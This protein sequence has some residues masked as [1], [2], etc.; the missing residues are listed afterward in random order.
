[1]Q[2][3]R[4]GW[5]S[6]MNKHMEQDGW[7]L[8]SAIIMILFLTAVGFSIAELVALQ[9]QHTKREMYM[10]NAQLVAEAGI[11]QSVHE[12]NTDDSFAGYPTAQTFFDDST[13]GK[14]TFSTAVT[15]NSDGTSKTII[16]T[17][18]VY[19]TDTDPNP[20]LTRKVKVTV[21]G[22]GSSGYSVATGPGGLILGGSASITN[23][24]VYVDGTITMTGSSKIGT[25]S[26][27]VNV[28][29]GN[30]ACPKGSSPGSSYP[31]V[32][33]D[34]SQPIS[35]DWSTNIYGT[36]CATGQ[37][38][39]GPNNNIQG[40]NGGAGLEVGCTAPSVTPPTYDRSGIISGITDTES[41]TSGSYAC[42][43]NKTII[44]PAN[45]EL[46]GGTISWGNS[47]KITISGDV[48]IP[49]NLS[50]GGAVQITAAD[51]LG[52]TRPVILVDGT[53]NVAGSAAMIAN[54][55][56]SG[57]DFVSFKN[58]TGNPGGIPTGT[59]LYNSQQ[60]QNVNVGG[61]ASSAG[62]VFDAYWSEATLT[63]SGNVGAAAGQTVNLDGAGTVIFGTK[64]TSGSK[65]WAITSY[66][67]LNS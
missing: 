10:Q 60:E 65:T 8:V 12:L 28:D 44:L 56:G 25:S 61:A 4:R 47:C 49:G 40:G 66:Q 20:Y 17:G 50:I 13:Q 1:V 45:I 38:S 37:T 41:G 14:G 27:P 53:I 3:I 23:S 15:D 67:M 36:V 5:S 2:V 19:R 24:N 18:E 39:T 55:S 7:V 57:I 43:G 6:G 30:I 42:N 29:V 63:G 48:Y 11:E 26:N 59:V 54:S 35:M 58:A 34:G 52:T 9:Y 46:T 22:T 33:T 62:M 32:C 64:L 51:S 21:V 16:S 31:E